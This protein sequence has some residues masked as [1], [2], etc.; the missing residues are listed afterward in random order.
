MQKVVEWASAE[1]RVQF[2][3]QGKEGGQA[4]EPEYVTECEHGET[5]EKHRVGGI[6]CNLAFQYWKG[7]GR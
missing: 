2:S 4:V 1:K 5:I 7:R 3:T 6:R